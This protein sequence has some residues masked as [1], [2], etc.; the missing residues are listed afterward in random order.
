MRKIADRGFTVTVLRP[1]M[2]YGK[3][4]KGNYLTL[5]KIAKRLL[6]FPDCHN[7][8]SMLYI[9]NLCEFLCQVMIKGE[10]GI[11]W[12]QNAEYSQTSEIVKTIAEFSGHQI[13]V[14]KAFN[15]AVIVAST[16]PI[17]R[18]N[19]LA[20]KAFGNMSYD[21]ELSR[22]D[23]AYQVVK[24]RESIRRIEQL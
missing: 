11:F 14:S 16:F 6:I 4:S 9:D 12:P 23:F 17:R 22:C 18:I 8:R 19:R 15:W 13:I 24:L 5:S 10:G 20:N 7:E 21:H 2:I 1:P 3:E